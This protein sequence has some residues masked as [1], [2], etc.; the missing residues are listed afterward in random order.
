LRTKFYAEDE[1][2]GTPGTYIKTGD[3]WTRQP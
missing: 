2:Y 3:G 1:N